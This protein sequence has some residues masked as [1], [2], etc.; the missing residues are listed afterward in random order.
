MQ[1]EVPG[2]AYAVFMQKE[3]KVEPD[4]NQNSRSY[5]EFVEKVRME[6]Q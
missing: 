6:D 4:Y 3:K 2:L 1:Y 5:S